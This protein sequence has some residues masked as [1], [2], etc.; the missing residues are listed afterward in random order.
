MF[1]GLCLKTYNG[2]SFQMADL[3]GDLEL[4]FLE[5]DSSSPNPCADHLAHDGRCIFA[6]SRGELL[7]C[8]YRKKGHG[9]AACPT[10]FCWTD[11][12]FKNFRRRMMTR[13]RTH[14]DSSCY[15]PT[16]ADLLRE[17]RSRYGNQQHTSPSAPGHHLPSGP[18]GVP[19]S[20]APP[21]FPSPG[22]FPPYPM[23]FGYPQ[24]PYVPRPFPGFPGPPPT[25]QPDPV[26]EESSSSESEADPPSRFILMDLASKWAPDM[27]KKSVPQDDDPATGAF[28][29]DA[30]A[31]PSSS[32]RVQADE[33]LCGSFLRGV[34]YHLR[35]PPQ[36]LKALLSSLPSCDPGVPKF[37]HSPLPAD[38]YAFGDHASNMPSFL[39]QTALRCPQSHFHKWSS[40]S[41]PKDISG[42]WS[43]VS[44]GFL[45]LMEI[46]SLSSL[47]MHNPQIDSATR[48][49][50]LR[51]MRSML[52]G[53]AFTMGS[54]GHSSLVSARQLYLQVMGQFSS[55]AFAAEPFTLSSPLGASGVSLWSSGPSD[56]AQTCNL[57]QSQAR[58]RSQQSSGHQKLKKQK[59]QQQKPRFKPYPRPK[60]LP[61]QNQP[62]SSGSRSADKSGKQQQQ[63][64][65]SQRGGNQ[66]GRGGKKRF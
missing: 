63:Q 55:P 25:I 12:E 53:A 60:N 28:G 66:G 21:S 46:S 13:V 29:F 8:L 26:P 45:Y 31:P 3:F 43:A 39:S 64:S 32:G 52:L 9:V 30:V 19:G 48:E 5:V 14:L 27:L 36:Q 37:E 56:L 50:I 38:A 23:V 15:T 65:K 34:N 17:M 47:L 22:G 1:R 54:L 10:C 6:L 18:P 41:I 2:L 49:S 62:S 44:R 33:G 61:A 4:D 58:P 11:N 20:S 16:L 59:G 42:R 24:G 35:G 57:L 7:R 51:Q 40:P